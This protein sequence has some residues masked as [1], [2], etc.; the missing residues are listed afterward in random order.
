MSNNDFSQLENRVRSLENDS[1][2]LKTAAAILV[3]AALGFWGISSVYT[4]PNAVN[5][6]LENDSSKQLKDKLKSAVD[7]AVADQTVLN[8]QLEQLKS[9]ALFS[10]PND[11]SVADQKGNPNSN[12]WAS[13]G[14]V[15]Q[16]T[17]ETKCYNY[18]WSNLKMEKLPR[19]CSP[20]LRP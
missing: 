2:K 5:N 13:F 15:G 4:I 18:V 19:N 7:S 14:C 8:D 1:V 11:S 20:L 3:A 9:L 10:C 6:A 16:V 17:T 12:A